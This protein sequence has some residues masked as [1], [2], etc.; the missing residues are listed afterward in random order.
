MSKTPI[1]IYR[2]PLLFIG[3]LTMAI[4]VLA[5][6]M[7]IGWVIPLISENFPVL[8]GPFMICG[9]L[10]TVIGLERAVASEHRWSYLVPILTATAML[11]IFAVLPLSVAK[12]MF[13]IAA[14]ILSVHYLFVLKRFPSLHLGVMSAGAFLWMI[15]NLFWLLNF[16]YGNVVLWWSGFL[17]MTIAGERLELSRI[18]QISRESKFWFVLIQIV[19]TLGILM[20]TFEFFIGARI[21]AL[22]MLLMAVWLMRF[23]LAFKSVKQKDLTRFIALALIA[24]FVWLGIG[25]IIGMFYG[26]ATSGPLYDSFLHAVFLGFVFSMIFGHAPIIFPAILNV[27]MNYTSRFYIHLAL[28]HLSLILR[29]AGDLG[30][31]LEGRQWGAMLNGIAIAIFIL[32]TVTSIR[33]KPA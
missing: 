3:L 28:L 17:V 13:F 6:L 2:L 16:A 26:N 15:G 1:A 5:G 19:F 14:A 12:W 24:G 33:K 7:R 32:N 21:A 4:G 10:G 8:H 31:W 27:Q 20:A 23:D 29:V 18:L 25:G 22:A 11:A 30:G 9:F